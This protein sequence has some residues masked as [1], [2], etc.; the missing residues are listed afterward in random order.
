MRKRQGNKRK[1]KGHSGVTNAPEGNLCPPK[2]PT[3][4]PPTQESR[5]GQIKILPYPKAGERAAS[6]TPKKEER[7]AESSGRLGGSTDL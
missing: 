3:E 2:T 7:G 5:E 1:K 4:V 6:L